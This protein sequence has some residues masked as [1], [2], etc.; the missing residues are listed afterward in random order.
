MKESVDERRMVYPREIYYMVFGQK[1]ITCLHTNFN[2]IPLYFCIVGNTIYFWKYEGRGIFGISSIICS[3]SCARHSDLIYLDTW[4]CQV[5]HLLK[6]PAYF[7]SSISI[8]SHFYLSI[9]IMLSNW[10]RIPFSD[11]LLCA[12]MFFSLPMYVLLSLF[13]LQKTLLT[14]LY[15]IDEICRKTN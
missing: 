3:F 1:K 13:R 2:Q 9:S 14:P 6:S 8:R 10:M 12:R 15:F 11:I 5:W 4:F 7:T